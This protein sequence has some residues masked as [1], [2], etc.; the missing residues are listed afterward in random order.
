MKSLIKRGPEGQFFFYKKH[1]YF[2]GGSIAAVGSRLAVLL[3]C[4]RNFLDNGEI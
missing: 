4:P 2:G 3:A 1:F